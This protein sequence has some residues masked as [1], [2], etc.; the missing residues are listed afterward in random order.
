MNYVK[1]KDHPYLIR[2]LKSKAVLNT[3]I[4]GKK[5]FIKRRNELRSLREALKEQDSLKK[6]ITEL[7]EQLNNLME[8]VRRLD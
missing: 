4:E 2:D 3:N 5:A 8:Y 6:E 7:R 1:I